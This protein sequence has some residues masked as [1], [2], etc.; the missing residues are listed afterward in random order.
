[1]WKFCL[2]FLERPFHILSTTAYLESPKAALCSLKPPQAPSLSPEKR[3]TRNMG[4]HLPS[5]ERGPSGGRA[6]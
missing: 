3:L 2:R 6:C 4:C 1:M 5:A